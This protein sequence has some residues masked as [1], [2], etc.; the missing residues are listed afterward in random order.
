MS[1]Q[2]DRFC[3]DLKVRLNGIESHLAQVKEK[4]VTAS[5]DA[6]DTI[7]TKLDDAKTRFEAKKQELAEVQVKL[8]QRLETK[9][10]EVEA[11]IAEWKEKRDQEK[12]LNHA[13]Q[14]EEYALAA[15]VFAAAAAEE[16]EVA[17][18]EAIAARKAADSLTLS[19][20]ALSDSSEA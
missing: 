13:D 5:K 6:E 14:A 12:L 18:L 1:E 16:A 15:I 11:E 4:L 10:I 3:D 7:K 20:V 17:V 9:K 19:S 2:I 8:A